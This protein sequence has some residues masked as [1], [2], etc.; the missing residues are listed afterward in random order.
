M[1]WDELASKV[2]ILATRM[3][4]MG[5]KPGDAVCCLMPNIPETVIAML[6]SISIGALWSN[7]APEFGRKTILDRF[8]QIKPKWLFVADGYQFGGKPF[9]RRDE[10]VAIASAMADSLQLV[11]YLPYLDAENTTA[12]VDAALWNELLTGEDP[13]RDVFRFERVAHDHPLW[14]LFS[15][16]T[17]GLPKAIVHSHVGAL[18]EMMKTMTFHMDLQRDDISFFYT[19]TGWVMF[20]QSRVTDARCVMEN[21]R[22]YQG[23]HFWGQPHL[24]AVNGSTGG[25]SR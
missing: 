16:G 20:N 22:G 1:S 8:T 24:R 3:R 14:V 5:V 25:P 17:T 12:P 19:T 18:M 23:H 4:T 6:A 9:D 10:I 21:G 7:A 2:R 11:V 15:S 13:G